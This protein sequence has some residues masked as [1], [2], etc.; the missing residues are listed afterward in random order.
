[1]HINFLICKS[2]ECV[3]LKKTGNG[4]IFLFL[5]DVP[6]T[7]WV[8]LARGG[9]WR[10]ERGGENKKQVFVYGRRSTEALKTFVISEMSTINSLGLRQFS[11]SECCL[12]FFRVTYPTLLVM[13]FCIGSELLSGDEPDRCHSAHVHE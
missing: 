1:M 9:R 10:G 2:E 13:W 5:P 6:S 7:K 3:G 11:M 4:T 8:K 12:M